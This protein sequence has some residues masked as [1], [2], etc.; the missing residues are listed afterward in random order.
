[1]SRYGFTLRTRGGQRVDNVMLIAASQDEAERRLRQMYP[2][3]SIIERRTHAL[4]PRLEPRA[5]A[6]RAKVANAS[7]A[8]DEPNGR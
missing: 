4:P 7:Y 5:D 8:P 2:D 1:M 3:C 6:V